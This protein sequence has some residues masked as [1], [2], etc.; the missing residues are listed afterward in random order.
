VVNVS[1]A[2]AEVPAAVVKMMPLPA[3]QVTVNAAPAATPEVVIHE[4]QQAPRKLRIV[5]NRAGEMT[6]IIEESA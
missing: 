2:A 6:N 4:A 1:V 3:P 5:R